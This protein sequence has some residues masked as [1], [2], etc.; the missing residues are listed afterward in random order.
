MKERMYMS[1]HQKHQ[2]KNHITNCRQSLSLINS[3]QRQDWC[4]LL[5]TPNFDTQAAIY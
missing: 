2:N 4:F 1:Q 3:D 5:W